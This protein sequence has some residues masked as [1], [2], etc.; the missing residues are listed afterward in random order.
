MSCVSK[1]HI[2]I[3]YPLCVWTG[4]PSRRKCCCALLAWRFCVYLLAVV[5]LAL[6]ACFSACLLSLWMF[7]D[8][9]GWLLGTFELGSGSC[10]LTFA[11]LV[12]MVL[13]MVSKYGVRIELEFRSRFD[14]SCCAW[15]FSECGGFLG[16]NSDFR[17]RIIKPDRFAW[18]SRIADHMGRACLSTM[19]VVIN[20]PLNEESLELYMHTATD[21][22]NILASFCLHPVQYLCCIYIM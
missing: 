5:C 14:S 6:L 19:C 21:L 7:W 8:R 3:A 22:R 9:F 2:S 12:W 10:F 1:L 4:W 18:S 13:E 15:Q 11:G 16:S 20:G 17:P